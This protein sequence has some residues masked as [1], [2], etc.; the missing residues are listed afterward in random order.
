MSWKD[1]EPAVITLVEEA[2]SQ[3]DKSQRERPV[4]SNHGE[5]LPCRHPPSVSTCQRVDVCVRPGPAGRVEVIGRI[6]V[7]GG[8]ASLG[9]F[10][11]AYDFKTIAG[12]CLTKPNVFHYL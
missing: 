11:F 2:K 5:L 9:Y 1:R 6:T 12:K 3:R 4:V 10:N 8:R 7:L